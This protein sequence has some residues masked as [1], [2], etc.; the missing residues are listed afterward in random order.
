MQILIA[1]PS[2]V[3]E[4]T[5]AGNVYLGGY[6]AALNVDFL[7]ESRVVLVANAAPGL[8]KVLGPRYAASRRKAWDK[9]KE[10]G[11]EEL[12]VDW[13]DRPSQKL[14]AELIGDVVTR[15]RMILMK[16]ASFSLTP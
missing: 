14:E 6:K 3:W 16:G 8:R 13:E 9:L 12:E 7:L 10:R 1:V 4:G 2:L 5:A 15:I 11:V